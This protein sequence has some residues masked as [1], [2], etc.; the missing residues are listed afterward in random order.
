MIKIIDR[1]PNVEAFSWVLIMMQNAIPAK[2]RNIITVEDISNIRRPLLSM[3][4]IASKK[5][6]KKWKTKSKRPEI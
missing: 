3:I 4:I 1:L 5:I 2:H 6:I